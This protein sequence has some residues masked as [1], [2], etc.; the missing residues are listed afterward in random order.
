[1]YVICDKRNS[2]SGMIMARI[3][4]NGRADQQRWF[5][6]SEQKLH[7]FCQDRSIDKCLLTMIY[8]SGEDVSNYQ[9]H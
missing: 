6:N 4:W 8:H 3:R 7:Y 2:T 9:A 5:L 1:M